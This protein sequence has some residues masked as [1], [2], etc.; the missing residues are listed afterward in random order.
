MIGIVIAAI[1]IGYDP[2]LASI[3]YSF[4]A[5]F[6]VFIFTTS[7]AIYLLMAVIGQVHIDVGKTIAGKDRELADALRQSRGL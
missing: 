6:S 5:N 2:T 4:R 1:V 3:D 7:F